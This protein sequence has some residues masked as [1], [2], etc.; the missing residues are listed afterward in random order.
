MLFFPPVPHRQV[1]DHTREKTTLRQAEE[2]SCDKEASHIL[3]DTE[4]CCD[5]A[6]GEGKGGK[7][8]FGRSQFENDV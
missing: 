2:E 1:E 6:P 4:Q 8:Y 5:Y 3:G 7:P